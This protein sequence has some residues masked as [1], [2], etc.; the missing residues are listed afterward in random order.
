VVRLVPDP[1]ILKDIALP[2]ASGIFGEPALVGDRVFVAD[3][4]G[5]VFMMDADP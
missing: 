1:V 3:T 2:G 5:K 4:G